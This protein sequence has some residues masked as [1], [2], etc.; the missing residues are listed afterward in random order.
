MTLIGTEGGFLDGGLAPKG[1]VYN[2]TAAMPLVV[3][4]ARQSAST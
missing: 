1:V 2:N 3:A 4:P